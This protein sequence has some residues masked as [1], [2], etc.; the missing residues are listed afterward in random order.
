MERADRYVTVNALAER[1]SVHIETVRRWI[2]DGK[3]PNAIKLP[4]GREWRIPESDVQAFIEAGKR[5][6]AR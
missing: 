2:R 4:D 1:L 3:F 5:D 6:A